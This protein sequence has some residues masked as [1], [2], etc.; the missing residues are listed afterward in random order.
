[1]GQAGVGKAG[2]VAARVTR[3]AIERMKKPV[4]PKKNT[5]VIF[6]TSPAPRTPR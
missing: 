1:M 2:R 3:L 6:Y 4:D 5:L